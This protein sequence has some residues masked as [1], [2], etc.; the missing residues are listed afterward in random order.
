MPV[1]INEA[2]DAHEAAAATKARQARSELPK[3]VVNSMLAGAYVGVAV[4]L[5]VIVSATFVSAKSPSTKLVQGSVFGIALTLVVFAG[6]ELFTGN[7]MVMLQG[8]ARRTVRVADVATVWVASLLGNLIGA[9][10][11]AALVNASGVISVSPTPGQQSP[12]LASLAGII[13][14]KAGLTG[15]QLFFRSVL[16]NLLVCLALWMAARTRSD[17][18]KLICLWWALLAFVA[19]GFEHSVANMTIF[20]LGIFGHVPGATWAEMTRNLLYTVSGNIVGGGLLVGL[21]YSWAGREAG[22]PGFAADVRA[23]DSVVTAVPTV[24]LVGANSPSMR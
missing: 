15:G 13:K 14:A 7:V 5:L 17:A 6:A 16:C 1:P 12:S 18:A 9:L 23:T 10:G 8:L 19:S 24:D 3:Y 21:A 2:L 11:F 20:G 22:T 4:V